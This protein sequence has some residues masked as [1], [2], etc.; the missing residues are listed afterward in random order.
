MSSMYSVAGAL[1]T[2]VRTGRLGFGDSL[3]DAEVLE[4]WASA[5]AKG[6]LEGRRAMLE[7]CRFLEGLF[8]GMLGGDARPGAGA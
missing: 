8:G 4:A 6:G 2:E 7:L 5:M 1:W 3:Q